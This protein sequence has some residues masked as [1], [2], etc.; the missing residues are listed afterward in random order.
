MGEDKGN[1]E[2]NEAVLVE[3]GVKWFEDLCKDEGASRSQMDKLALV[4]HAFMLELGFS[5]ENPKA[6][7]E[8]WKTPAG[9]T[10]RYFYPPTSDHDVIL[11]VT[12]LGPMVKIHGTHTGSKSTFSTSKI[13]PTE[14]ITEK[15]GKFEFKN[16]KRMARVF[17]NEVGVPLLN[18][19]RTH[20]G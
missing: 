6:L 17:K 18:S 11:T 3:E 4:A 7:P 1:I 20:L 2:M 9:H 5:V 13:K 19:V 12:N 15:E 16:L 8:N 10:T 14:F